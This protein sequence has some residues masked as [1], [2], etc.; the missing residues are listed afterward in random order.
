MTHVFRVLE[1]SSS[2]PPPI[3]P[4]SATTH[5]QNMKTTRRRMFF[6]F[7]SPLS[8]SSTPPLQ[9]L[10]TSTRAAEHKKHMPRHMFFVLS[11]STLPFLRP[12]PWA[13]FS[14]LGPIPSSLAA[15]HVKRTQVDT[16]YVFI[17]LPFLS[18]TK[19][20]PYGHVFVLERRGG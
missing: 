20:C 5:L 3:Q 13:R 12:N 14:C 16:F 1:L 19:M 8:Q 2:T 7:W 6:M 10:P 9:G 17:T 15:Q 4:T 18:N 11:G